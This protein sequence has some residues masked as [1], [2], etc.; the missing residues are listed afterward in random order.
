MHCDS[1]KNYIIKIYFCSLR[2]CGERYQNPHQLFSKQLDFTL[3]VYLTMKDYGFRYLFAL[4]TS[5][6]LIC[7]AAAS[8]LNS[9][10]ASR[11]WTFEEISP[12]VKL[13]WHPCF[14]TYSCAMLDVS[15]VHGSSSLTA[16]GI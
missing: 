14:E 12:S 5:L 9:R 7:T 15:F 6:S 1:K 4:P 13:V 11:Q 16:I 3:I 8:P 2:G 10:D